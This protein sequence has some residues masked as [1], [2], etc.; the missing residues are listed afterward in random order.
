MLKNTNFTL[1]A[2]VNGEKFGLGEQIVGPRKDHLAG[3]SIL[4]EELV[5]IHRVIA[6]KYC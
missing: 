5:R 3:R 2:S 1:V 4:L 6:F